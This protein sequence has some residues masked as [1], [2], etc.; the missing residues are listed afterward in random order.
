VTRPSEG[1]ISVLRE[2]STD[3]GAPTAS[4]AAVPDVTEPN[5]TG[6]DAA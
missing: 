3:V 4:L 2:F 6:V 5:G 1:N